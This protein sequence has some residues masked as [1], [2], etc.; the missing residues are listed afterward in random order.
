MTSNDTILGVVLQHDE[1]DWA[2]I[3]D[4]L[5]SELVD[6]FMWMHEA[7]LDGGGRVHAYK[8]TATRRYLHITGDG[9]AFDYVGYCTYAPIRL[10]RAIDL[11]FEGWGEQ[12]PD[13][14]DVAMLEAAL[15]R[16][17]ERPD[18]G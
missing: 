15:E 12:R 3:L 14:A 11:A 1:P 17:L 8:H 13:P 18:P 5:G 9:R 4:L 16:A 2:P 6:W 7:A 10:S